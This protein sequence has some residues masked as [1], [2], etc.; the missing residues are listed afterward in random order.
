MTTRTVLDQLDDSRGNQ[1]LGQRPRAAL[2]HPL[3]AERLT[4]R[5]RVEQLACGL[6]QGREPL[7]DQLSQTWRGGDRAPQLP[8]PP[9]SRQCSR[10]DQTEDQLT[11][12]EEVAAGSGD[13]GLPSTT[14]DPAREDLVHQVGHVLR[15]Q[16][17]QVDPGDHLI[18]PQQGHRLRDYL[19]VA[20]REHEIDPI[21]ERQVQQQDRG[22]IVEQVDVVHHEQEPV[23]VVESFDQVL[24][25]STQASCLAVVCTRRCQ[26][27]GERTQGHA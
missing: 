9:L 4:E 23:T 7:L 18:P 3:C 6:T 16:R 13:E 12:V 27:L 17:R 10:V 2:S 20:H 25:G 19:T 24:C 22:R 15:G 21:R 1:F 26:H 8:V 11:Q 5:Q 14:V